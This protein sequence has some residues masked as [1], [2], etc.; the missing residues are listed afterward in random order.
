MLSR[1]QFLELLRD[2]LSHLHDPDALCRNRLATLFG[3]AHHAD[4]YSALQRVLTEAIASLEPGPDVPSGSRAWRIYDLLTCRYVQELSAPVVANQLGLSVRH[5]RREQRA[6]LEALAHRLWEQFDLEETAQKDVSTETMAQAGR[7]DASVTEELAWL[8]DTP[9]ER[10]TDLE[11][12]L[13]TALDLVRPLAAQHRVR[14][15]SRL[16]GSLPGLAVH[17]VALNQVLLNLLSA[18]IHRTSGGWVRIST[19]PLRWEVEV[20]VQ[21]TRLFSAPQP[22]SDEDATSLDMAHELVDMCGG[23]LI[24][25][26]DGDAFGATLTF[27]AFEQ[28]PVLVIDDNA[29]ALQLFKHYASGTRYRFLGTRD[30]EQALTLAEKLSPQIVVLDVMMPQ[31][32]G[33]QVLGWLRQH[34]LT[35]H[36]PIVVCTILTQEELAF[37]L[38]ASTFLHKPVTRRAFLDALDAQAA[39]MEPESG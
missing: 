21:C 12:V 19:R 2:G 18:A 25:S 36:I 37:S 30:P 28:L 1:E 7:P 16:A 33:W 34:P 29:D 26:T 11:E 22:V 24:L 20:Q 9:S 6:A 38:G 14:L 31:I 23:R 35:S 32:D 10:P 39:R 17:P 13:H 5:L 3:V 4:M 27:P 8:R 15:E